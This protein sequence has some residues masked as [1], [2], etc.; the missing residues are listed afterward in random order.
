MRRLLFAL[1]AAQLG[2]CAADPSPVERPVTEVDAADAAAE[3][4]VASVRTDPPLGLDAGATVGDATDTD[5]DT[6]TDRAPDTATPEAERPA[7]ACWITSPTAGATLPAGEPVRFAA[8][9]EGGEAVLVWTVPGA[10]YVIGDAFDLTVPIGHHT[11]ALEGST[12]D[13]GTCQDTID[14]VVAP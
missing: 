9:V 1:C 7:L 6:D 11:I 3:P 10:G 4:P 13:G 5:F 2:A 12:E 14:L 8:A